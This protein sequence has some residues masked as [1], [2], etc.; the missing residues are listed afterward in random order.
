[1][2]QLYQQFRALGLRHLVVVN[3]DNAVV[4][5]VTRKDLAR[6][7]YTYVHSFHSPK[8]SFTA[9]AFISFTKLFLRQGKELILVCH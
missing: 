3:D 2:F 6:Y 4:G 1:M 5:L 9:L 7:I 8:K